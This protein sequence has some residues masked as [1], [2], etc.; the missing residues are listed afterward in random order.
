MVRIKT[1]KV[2]EGE[3]QSPM[4]AIDPDIQPY[5]CLFPH[6]TLKLLQASF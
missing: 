2:I 3:D 6:G 4:G 5:L 1:M